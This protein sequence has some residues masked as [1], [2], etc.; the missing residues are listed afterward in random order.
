MKKYIFFIAVL[1]GSISLAQ[2][3]FVTGLFAGEYKTIIDMDDNKVEVP[4]DPKHIACMHA[5]SSNRIIILG[6][7][8]RLAL[9]M[10]PS[11][12]AY[13]LYPE[14]KNVE[15]VEPPYTGNV[16]R[17]LKLN[18]DLVLYSPFPGEAKK[19][20]EAGISFACGFS[21]DKRPRTLDE[22]I[23]NFKRQVTFFGDLLGP[24]AK[25]R[26]A[27]YNKYF[28]DKINKLLSI[29]AKI[30]KKDWPKVYYGGRSG[31]PLYSQGKASVM[32]WFTEVAGGNY[33]PKVL[34]GNFCEADMEKVMSWDP[35]I[36]LMSGAGN[37]MDTIS[38]NPNWTSMRA[39]KK[40]KSYV[41]PVGTFLWEQAGGESVLLAIYMAKLFHPESFKDW[42]MIKEMRTFFSEVYGKQ[43]TDEDAERILK[44]LPPL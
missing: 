2:G 18:V 13:K 5:V 11:A 12:W 38:K 8:D 37:A 33:L 39:V 36:I 22:F 6:K 32:Q 16:E 3:L 41:I 29:T 17:M 34:E 1:I 25:A 15:I 40:G 23:D 42:D 14:L 26:A 27:K 7:G 28:D 20:K 24:D 44:C 10:K 4:V 31:N 21:A 19:Y 43:I 9:V 35:D 30:D